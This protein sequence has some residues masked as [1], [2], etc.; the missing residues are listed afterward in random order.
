MADEISNAEKLLAE[1]NKLDKE[2]NQN[3]KEFNR[4][5]EKSTAETSDKFK[6]LVNNLKE[7]QPETAKIVADFKNAGENTLK[8]A[9]ISRKLNLAMEA[10]AELEKKSF[11]ELSMEQ[12]SAIESMFGGNLEQLKELEGNLSAIKSKIE[13]TEYQIAGMEDGRKINAEERAKI[14]EEITEVSKS[15]E[16]SAQEQEKINQAKQELLAMEQIDQRTLKKDAKIAFEQKKMELA[17]QMESSRL[18]IEGNKES[19]ELAKEK[20]ASLTSEKNA[21]KTRDDELVAMIEEDKSNLE[22]YKE[23]NKDL[24]IEETNVREDMTMG[25]EKAKNDQLSGLTEFSEGLKGITGFDLIGAFDDGVKMFNNVKKVGEGIFAASKSMING[26]KGMPAALKGLKVSV[27]GFIKGGV[28]AIRGAF[29]TI[30]TSLAAAGTALMTTLTAFAAG[31]AAFI[32]GL[33]ATAGGM[34]LAAAPYI[35]AGLAIVGLVMAGMKLYEESEGFK[36]AVD[37]VIGYFIDIKDSIF[38]IFGGF[39]DFFKGLFTGDF[40]LMFSGIKD[41]FGGLWDLIK[42]P[43]KAIGDFFKNVF[44]IDIMAKLKQ[45]AK[46]ILPGVVYRALFDDDVPEMNEQAKEKGLGAAEESGLYEKKG[47]GR[48]SVVNPDMIVTAPNNQLNAILAD[49][50]IN[51][52]TKELIQKELEARKGIIASYNE[53]KTA[54]DSGQS[55]L[56]DGSDASLVMELAEGEMTK[57]RTGSQI[58]QAT[59]DAQPNTG[60]PTGAGGETVV[61]QNNNNSST[62]IMNSTD[63]ARDE[64][65]RYYAALGVA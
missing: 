31:A 21:L 53:A 8:G 51:D 11:E 64:N 54:L 24:L 7:V 16:Q 46:A 38:K 35:L 10:A 13:T 9:L 43:F 30:G 62:N 20:V 49:N 48:A 61:Q 40:D 33:A 65:D 56:A 59:L 28:S 6:A 32:G 12:Q 37:T 5:L 45:M 19:D 25:L 55:T 47:I 4:D 14:D 29:T 52:E 41:V 15:L 44:G 36:A 17:G 26:L 58:E 42:A 34:L 60:T 63:T 50:D 27:G 3:R 23:Q 1:R 18:I 39:Y 2:S 22:S 57:R